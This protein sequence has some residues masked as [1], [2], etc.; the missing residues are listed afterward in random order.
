[1]KSIGTLAGDIAHDFNNVLGGIIGYGEMSL[2]H[3]EKDS[4][5]KKIS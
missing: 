1:M 2:Q 4:K 5:L 3:T